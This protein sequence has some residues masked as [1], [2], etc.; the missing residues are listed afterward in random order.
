M[1][2]GGIA[3]AGE[4]LFAPLRRAVAARTSKLTFD[5]TQI[6]PALLGP[7]AGVIGAAQWAREQIHE[8]Q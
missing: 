4:V 2:G 7:S 6:M 3:Q 8:V 1:I 5:V